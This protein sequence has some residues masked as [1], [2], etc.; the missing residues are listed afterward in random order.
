MSPER[1][2]IHKKNPLSFFLTPLESER[3]FQTDRK[4]KEKGL[5]RK[6]ILN[7]CA[8]AFQIFQKIPEHQNEQACRRIFPSMKAV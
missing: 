8:P 6:I 2:F 3:I 5:A 1:N 4:M 7:Y